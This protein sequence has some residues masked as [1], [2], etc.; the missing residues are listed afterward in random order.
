V[1][2]LQESSFN[3][4]ARRSGAING[5]P[6]DEYGN[7]LNDELVDRSFIEKRRNR[8]ANALIGSLTNS[9]TSDA[10]D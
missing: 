3:G 1:N 7:H 4:T 5:M 2:L 6:S 10:G 8:V 9:T